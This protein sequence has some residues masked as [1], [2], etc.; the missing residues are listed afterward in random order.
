MA[1]LL[2]AALGPMPVAAIGL[3]MM[4]A[5]CVLIADGLRRWR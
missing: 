3:G 5:G 4:L 1:E 2:I